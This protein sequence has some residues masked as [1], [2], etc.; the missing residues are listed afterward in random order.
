M[1]DVTRRALA[2]AAGLIGAGAA[3]TVA[4]QG[5]QQPPEL[6]GR[7]VDG[8]VELPPLAA[9]TEVQ[10]P[11]PNRDPVSKRLGVAVVGIG[12]LTMEQI[13]P[14]FGTAKHV[15]V[16]ALVSGDPAKARAVAAQ[17]GVPETHLYDYAGFDRL[18]DNPDVDFV[19]I[20]LP[21]D[22]H[23]EYTL[24]AAQAGKHVLC[25]KPMA[26]TVADAQR[27]VDGCRDAGKR[28][29]IAYRLQYEPQHRA[30]IRMARSG[31]Y[32]P[33][34]LIEA[35]HGQNQAP[36]QQWRHS[37]RQAGGGS[38]PDVGIYCLNAARYVTGEEPVEVSAMLTQPK[39][40][41]RFA[42]V[43]DVC[44]FTLRFP[45]GAVATCSSGYSFHKSAQMRVMMPEAWVELDPA[46]S[47]GGLA[48]RIGR[49]AGQASAVEERR[50]PD[51]NQFATEMDHFAEAI[52]AGREPHT[53]GT[54]GL[55][56]MRVIE[57]IYRAAR[58]GGTV[59]LPAVAGLDTT[60]GP[61]PQEAA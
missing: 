50:F 60:R 3:A 48:M 45:S 47:Y 40:D 16:T 58:D 52:R 14:A 53:P 15:R 26:T 36:N 31:Q 44:A 4:A 22:M 30:L 41:P 29:M 24:R 20:V 2:T 17:H 43:E 10:A 37:A 18:R 33:V 32:G 49:K 8:K 25:E 51:R 13:M 39:D 46:F 7:A 54:E 28:L 1:T 5:L 57:A 35:V 21:N 12:A 56:D 42:E 55:A 38:L 23:L 34:K 27:M 11:T 61:A 9:E 59:R 6:R 19:Y